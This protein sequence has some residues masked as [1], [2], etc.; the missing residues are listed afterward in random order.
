MSIF[1]GVGI[2][3]VS[4]VDSVQV[5]LVA[6]LTSPDAVERLPERQNTVTFLGVDVPRLYIA[7]FEQSAPLKLLA[8]L[9]L[10]GI[11]DD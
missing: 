8:A 6:D 1:R 7:P 3:S 2:V 9:R 5:R 11:S 4:T 10:A